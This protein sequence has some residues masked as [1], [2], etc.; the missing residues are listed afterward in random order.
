MSFTKDDR[1]ILGLYL[2]PG[3]WL[4]KDN[5]THVYGTLSPDECREIV[6]Y[7]S[8]P[9]AIDVCAQRQGFVIL[10]LPEKILPTNLPETGLINV[11]SSDIVGAVQDYF[12]SLLFMLCNEMCINHKG[13]GDGLIALLY[14]IEQLYRW[15]VIPNANLMEIV[16]SPCHPF[17]PNLFR[18]STVDGL[19]AMHKKTRGQL[20]IEDQVLRDPIPVKLLDKT[21]DRMFS[22]KYAEKDLQLIALLNKS[23]ASTNDG[24]FSQSHI[25]CWAVIEN[26]LHDLWDK[27]LDSKA[28]LTPDGL[29]RITS[30]RR[31]RLNNSDFTASVKIE[32]LELADV[33]SHQ[34]YTRLTPIRQAR[35]K[36]MHEL[37]PIS[38]ENS[39]QCYLLARDLLADKL[40]IDLK[41]P[42]GYYKFVE[43]VPFNKST[44]GYKQ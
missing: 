24:E 25:L 13:K 29:R 7:K 4:E 23:I 20:S 26:L 42:G 36:W 40:E 14:K 35:N 9:N 17:G 18:P 16:N 41:H 21:L 37:Q 38:Y 15:T 43:N 11:L 30:T 33:I 3:V 31:N 10:S 28:S 27:F 6:F 39:Q 44:R 22:S 19:M 32:V 5:V 12:N 8:L 1:L 2:E 34:T